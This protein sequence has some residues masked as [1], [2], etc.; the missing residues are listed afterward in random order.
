MNYFAFTLNLYTHTYVYITYSFTF[1]FHVQLLPKPQST[2][3]A[4]VHLLTRVSPTLPPPSSVSGRPTEA[5]TTT[6][7]SSTASGC[8]STA[9]PMC[10]GILDYDLTYNNNNGA[11]RDAASMEAYE[12]LITSNC[13][14]RAVEFICAALEPECRP[15]HIGQLPPCRRI[16]KGRKN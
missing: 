3:P 14:A 5:M 8:I 12:Q 7:A 9:L 16:C 10:R 11:P 2:P 6:P 1:S 15:A 4:N 13:S